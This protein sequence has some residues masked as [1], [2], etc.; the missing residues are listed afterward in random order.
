[1]FSSE[2]QAARFSQRLDLCH[3]FL[4]KLE[5]QVHLGLRGRGEGR[6]E[7]FDDHFHRVERIPGEAITGRPGDPSAGGCRAYQGGQD[8]AD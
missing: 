7:V 2:A 4:G 3:P 6:P 8:H 5:G 1:M